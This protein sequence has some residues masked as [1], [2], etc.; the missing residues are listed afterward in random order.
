MISQ[1][2]F[3]VLRPFYH[4]HRMNRDLNSHL[5]DLQQTNGEGLRRGIAEPPFN[6]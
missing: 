2:L 6:L 5:H 3:T 4:A 1:P